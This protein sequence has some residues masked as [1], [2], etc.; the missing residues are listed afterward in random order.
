VKA[1]DS[2]CRRTFIK[3][4][5]AIGLSITAS[6]RVGAQGRRM[7]ARLIPSTGE[8]IPVIGLG[9]SDEFDNIPSDGG[10]QLRQVIM[11]LVDNGG[12]VIDTAPGYGNAERILG[13]F[14]T[15]MGLMDTAF[16]S[17]KVKQTGAER[18]QQSLIRSQEFLGK[19]P[20]DL[21]MVHSLEDVHTQ[22]RN[23]HAWKDSGRVRYIG[24]TTYRSTGYDTVE[25]LIESGD[26]DFIQVDYSVVN[27]LAE[28]R[29]IPAAAAHGVAVMINSAFDNG[30]YFRRLQGQE[31][32]PWAAEFHCESWAQFSLKY[33]LS[34][35]DV[36]CVLAA[37]SNPEHMLDNARAGYLPW[38]D[39]ATRGRMAEHLRGL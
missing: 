15:E 5:T 10:E 9:T 12:T 27:T 30:S 33:I 13:R 16:V 24:V 19:H 14:L 34:N 2:I 20:L 4:A 11:T 21:L 3:L 28:Q 23:L 38:P 1:S 8:E 7:D 32:P 18:G 17:T 37:T 25:S 6:L 36:T 31:L 22:L 26:L 39:A 35:P 29:V